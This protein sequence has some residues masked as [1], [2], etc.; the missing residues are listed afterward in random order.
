M[1][2]FSALIAGVA[3]LVLASGWS[4]ELLTLFGQ[5]G[6][7]HTAIVIWSD[8]VQ[9]AA[10][11]AVVAAVP[12]HHH[13]HD[14]EEPGCDRPNAS[15]CTSASA[16]LAKRVNGPDADGQRRSSDW[17]QLSGPSGLA[18]RPPLQPPRPS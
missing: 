15:S 7:D 8:D 9:G 11:N 14:D 13:R 1:L 5:S 18:L 6:R 4:P 12:Q 10:R 3:I 16:A 17:P 2:R